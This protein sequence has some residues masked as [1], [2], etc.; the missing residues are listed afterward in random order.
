V[1]Q[2]KAKAV[3]LIEAEALRT[4]VDLK[5]RTRALAEWA[6]LQD[7]FGMTRIVDANSVRR[8]EAR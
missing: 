4:M 5:L 3:V 2:T 6:A 8:L 1:R 7:L